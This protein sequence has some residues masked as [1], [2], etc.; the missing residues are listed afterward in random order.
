MRVNTSN[1]IIAMTWLVRVIA[2][3]L[4]W[5]WARCNGLSKPSTPRSLTCEHILADIETPLHIG[6]RRVKELLTDKPGGSE[7]WGGVRIMRKQIL[8]M[9]AKMKRTDMYKKG[10]TKWFSSPPCSA[11]NTVRW[12]Q[13]PHGRLWLMFWWSRHC[14]SR[15]FLTQSGTFFSDSFQFFARFVPPKSSLKCIF[16]LRDWHFHYSVWAKRDSFWTLFHGFYLY[17]YLIER[18]FFT[19]LISFCSAFKTPV[20]Q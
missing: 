4:S 13:G 6:G 18:I 19:E 2:L 16:L 15:R 10:H 11:A 3:S 12:F 5:Q 17:C 9:A 1:Q 8:I 14:W 20:Q 7:G